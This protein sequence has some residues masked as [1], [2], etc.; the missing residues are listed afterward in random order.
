MLSK[1]GNRAQLRTVTM[2]PLKRQ[3]L[4]KCHCFPS[5][6][7]RRML[8]KTMS[9]GRKRLRH[10]PDTKKSKEANHTS[11]ETEEQLNSLLWRLN[12]LLI[13]W[14]PCILKKNLIVG[15]AHCPVLFF[16]S[17]SIDRNRHQILHGLHNFFSFRLRLGIKS[18]F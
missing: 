2:V 15:V 3:S 17:L 1:L 8:K 5:Q 10:W 16:S 6:R 13:W 18:L 12:N 9:L 4:T 14:Y 11:Q 7:S